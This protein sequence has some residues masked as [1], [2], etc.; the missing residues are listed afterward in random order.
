MIRERAAGSSSS[1][2]R[3]PATSLSND[4]ARLIFPAFEYI[5][6]AKETRTSWTQRPP[7]NPRP[8]NSSSSSPGS[9][10][11]GT[12]S[13][14]S[15]AASSARASSSSPPTSPAASGPRFSSSP[16]GSSG[17]LLSYFGALAF[18]EMGAAMPKAGGMYNFLQGGLRAA[19]RLPVRLDA[20]P[21]HRLRRHRHAD[22]GL[23]LELP[24]LFRRHLSLRPEAGRP[25][26]SSLFLVGVNYVGVALGGQPPEPPDRDQVRRPGRRLRHRL[27]LRQGRQR[28]QLGPTARCR[29]VSGNFLGASASPWSP[30]LWAY[31]GWEGATYSAGEVKNPE[32]NLPLGLLRRHHGLHRHLHPG[33]HG[34][35][36]CLPRRPDRRVAADRQRRH[37]RRRRPGRRLDHLLHH[38][39]LDHGRHQPEHPLLAAR[40]FRHGPGRALLQ[41]DR[42]ASTPGSGRRTSPS[43][44]WA[45]GAWSSPSSS[46][47]SRASSP[48]SSSASGSSSA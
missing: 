15:S 23:R 46:R 28:G 38:P 9:S 25:W 36:L 5:Y 27:H 47:P 41:E 35:S 11:S 16:S 29:P 10:G 21:G 18:A 39:L 17:G 13:R 2:T 45:S 7:E 32:R 6:P 24:P 30:S 22:R 48:T 20:L 3:A 31:K 8:T 33:Q 43:S 40:L 4:P 1:A 14:S 42:R 37:E 44:P 34:L 12:S 26:P 19:A